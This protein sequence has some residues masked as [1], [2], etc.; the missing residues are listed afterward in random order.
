MELISARLKNLRSQKRVD[1]DQSKQGAK[2]ET[3]TRE[4]LRGARDENND[5]R[6][7]KEIPP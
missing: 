5:F 6:E 7:I 1:F 4:S 3:T 2:I